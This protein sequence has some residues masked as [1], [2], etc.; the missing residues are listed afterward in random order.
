MFGEDLNLLQLGLLGVA[1]LP[2]LHLR[3]HGLDVY[4]TEERTNVFT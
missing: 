4:L 2:R 3:Q 1:E